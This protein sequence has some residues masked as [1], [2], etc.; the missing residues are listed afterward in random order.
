MSAVTENTGADV[1]SVTPGRSGIERTRSIVRYSIGPLLALSFILWTVIIFT[2]EYDS[3]T[4]R[5]INGES[6]RRAFGEHWAMTWRATLAIL[7]LALPAG[8]ALSRNWARRIR[9]T[10]VS[11]LSFAQALPAVGVLFLLPSFMGYGRT[12][13]VVGIV[14]ASFLPV[15]R[16]VLVGLERVD[17]SL[18]EAARGIGMSSMQT[19]FKV[20]I[21]LA[22]PVIVAGIR[23][24]LVLAIGTAALGGFINAGGLGNFIVTGSKLQRDEVLLTGTLMV[25]ALALLVDWLGAIA[26]RVLRPAGV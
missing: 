3:I 16:N 1:G 8:L 20:E 23:V 7:L 19:L 10:M 26:E 12:T 21:P 14:I 9:P 2:G 15:L 11:V 17:V 24:S 6:L 4:E 22:V 25:A 13:A 5:S 18:V